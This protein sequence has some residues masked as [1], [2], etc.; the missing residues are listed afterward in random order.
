MRLLTIP[1]VAERLGLKPATIRFWIWTR[2]IEVVKLGRAV[3]ISE[4]T[5]RELIERGTVPAR[6]S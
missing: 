4:A 6:R 5:I 2:K 1:E 3:R